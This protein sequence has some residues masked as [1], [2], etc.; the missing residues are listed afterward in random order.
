M[1][2]I[3]TATSSDIYPANSLTWGNL[4]EPY[5]D[6]NACAVCNIIPQQPWSLAACAACEEQGKQSYEDRYFEGRYLGQFRDTGTQPLAPRP[7][8]MSMMNQPLCRG[9]SWQFYGCNQ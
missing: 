1:E 2:N 3:F 7:G 4:H 9:N 8:Y 6:M 5:D